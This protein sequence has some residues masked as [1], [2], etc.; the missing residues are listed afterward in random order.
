MATDI[1]KSKNLQIS[2]QNHQFKALRLLEAV[3]LEAVKCSL[4][5]LA[6]LVGPEHPPGVGHDLVQGLEGL[7][8]PCLRYEV[9]AEF[10]RPVMEE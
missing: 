3:S 2:S 7:L 8:L 9:L 6:I 5:P 10:Y 4:G 1:I